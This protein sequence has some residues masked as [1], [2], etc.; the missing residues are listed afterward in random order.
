[1]RSP[2]AKGV[3][4]LVVAAILVSVAEARPSDEPGSEDASGIRQI[5]DSAAPG[6]PTH[7]PLIAEA[8]RAFYDGRSHGHAWLEHGELSAAA[9]ALI[10]RVARAQRDGLAP[11]RSLRDV[12]DSLLESGQV[13]RVDVSLTEVFLTYGLLLGRGQVAPEAVHAD[14]HAKAPPP[15]DLLGALTAAVAGGDV[16]AALDRLAPSEPSYRGLREAL[17]RYLDLQAAGGWGVVPGGPVLKP[18]DTGARVQALRERL[19]KSGDLAPAAG[20]VG[21]TAGAAVTAYDEEVAAAVR[22]FQSRHGLAADG[23][24]GPTTLAALNVPLSTRVRQIALNMERHRWLPPLPP[25]RVS[26]NIPAQ[27][28]TAF[29]DDREVMRMRVVTGQSYTPTPVLAEGISHIIVNPSWDVPRSIA[30]RELLPEAKADPDRLRRRGIRIFTSYDDEAEEVPAWRVEWAAV[31]PD[32]FPHVLRQEP[33]DANPLG[34]LQFMFPNRFA[35]SLHDTPAAEVFDGRDRAL[36]HGCVRVERP[37]ALAA[38]ALR[39]DPRWN[40][41]TIERV[42][43]TGERRRIDLAR[44]LPVYLLYWTAWV[45]P[46]GG[47]NFREDLYG[48]DEQ[49]TLALMGLAS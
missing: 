7:H 6:S 21:A 11:L 35:V 31:D 15:P 28:L 8:T 20:G 17:G 27:R 19:R 10:E 16:N 41:E 22:R 23:M 26:V 49:L 2:L 45:E 30:A 13:D 12:V 9:R 38:F 5:L 40:R 44:A 43:A 24:V 47:V 39:D 33:G 25:R 48:F 37:L 42:V 29:D 1:M 14:W 36:S 4:A 32:D 18:G 34:R 3:A 46:D